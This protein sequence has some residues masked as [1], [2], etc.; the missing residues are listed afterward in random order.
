VK[1]KYNRDKFDNRWIF[2]ILV[3]AF[4]LLF[5]GLYLVF[6]PRVRI[7]NNEVAIGEEY[8]PSIKCY[9][10]FSDLSSKVK[11]EGKIDN[12]KVGEYTY[13]YKIKYFIYNVSG[14]YKVKVVDKV[15]PILELKGD[16]EKKVCPNA[17]YE[18]EGYSAIDDND[19]DIS[20][21]V[22]ISELEDKIIYK[23]KDSSGNES[24]KER[25]IIYKDE[26][27]P[28][29]EL[30]GGNTVTIYLGSKYTEPGYSASDLCDGDITDKVV[31]TGTV[32]TEKIGTYTISY[33]V[34]DSSDNKTSVERI[35]KV[36]KRPSNN[37]SSGGADGIIYLTFDDGPS[38]VTERILNILDEEGVKAT[39]FVCGANSYTSRAYNSGHTI[40]LHSNSHDYSYIYASSSNFFSD[41][42]AI[43]D[44]V[45]NVTGYRSNIIRF[46]GGSSNTISKRYS[47]GIMSYLT[48]EVVNRGYTYFDWNVDSN[49]AGG[50]TY[51]SNKIYSN[52]VNNL[53]HNKTNVVL[54]HDSGGHSSTADALRSIIQYGKN[55]GYE[56]RAI[57]SST[58]VVRHGVNN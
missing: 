33:E 2:I 49:D 21:K 31:S 18:E 38:F 14:K 13:N 48:T 35:V 52:V 19:G 10:L 57:T 54:M 29:I 56:F 40:A 36:I 17:K 51:N 30:K 16:S 22:A 11:V 25:K 44:K 41:L 42:T 23:V 55:N 32:D 27:S 12:T 9:N 39:F 26:E 34:S 50:D 8:K 46:P 4:V 7:T 43:S 58:P 37:Y 47:I 3:T 53:S 1:R 5:S 24:I 15:G 45:Y 6:M 20:D 28:S